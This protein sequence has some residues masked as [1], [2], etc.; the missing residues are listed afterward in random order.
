MKT[1]GL[2]RHAKSDW[3]DPSLADIDRP[4]NQ[5]GQKSA[6][7]M[8]PVLAECGFDLVLASTARRVRETLSGAWDGPVEWREAIYGAGPSQLLEMAANA[9]AGVERLLIVGHNPTMHGLATRLAVSGDTSLLA[10]LAEKF[11]TG[12]LAVIDLPIERWRD[13]EVGI[14]TLRRFIRP[15]DL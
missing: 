12:A 15:R 6:A 10:A 8:A 11:P 2:L 7:A 4:L 3:G 5:R 14:G 9:P 1:L 13:I